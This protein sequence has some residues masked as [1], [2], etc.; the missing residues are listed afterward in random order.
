MAN[1]ELI[2]DLGSQ[3]IS[4]ALKNDGFSDKIPSVVAYGGAEGHQI[5][6]V[7][8]DAI[9]LANTRGD[10]KLAWPIYEGCV[11]DSEGA[12]ALITTLLD[13]LVSR[14]LTAFSKCVVSCVS[15]CGMISS[16]KKNIEA[17]FLGLGA[18]SVSFVEAPIADSYALF[19]EFHARC[20]VIA[21]IG[22]DCTDLAVVSDGQIVSGCTL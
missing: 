21:D 10:V 12:K 15:P 22:R 11:N 14:R 6:A 19:D 7:G 5:M 2:F 20:G 8:V 3:Y 17:I 18:K 13:R 1:Y 4:A 16:D 9:K